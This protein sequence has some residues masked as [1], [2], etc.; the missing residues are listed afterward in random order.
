[1]PPPVQE[2]L[3]GLATEAVTIAAQPA[4]LAEAAPTL[5]ASLSL[6]LKFSVGRKQHERRTGCSLLRAVAGSLAAR[7]EGAARQAQHGAAGAAD[8]LVP[9]H[10]VLLHMA[11]IGTLVKDASEADAAGCPADSALLQAT[12]AS[13]PHVLVVLHRFSDL[14]DSVR[15]ATGAGSEASSGG[16]APTSDSSD[17]RGP[18]AAA[19]PEGSV[20]KWKARQGAGLVVAVQWQHVGQALS[21]SRAEWVTACCCCS[22]GRVLHDPFAAKLVFDS[23][24][25]GLIDALVCLDAVKE[26]LP[27][28]ETAEV[29]AAAAAAADRA[30]RLLPR[31]WH[32]PVVVGGA[33]GGQERVVPAHAAPA[34]GS[35]GMAGSLA[36]NAP[37][38]LGLTLCAL[39]FTLCATAANSNV[40]SETA[41][42]AV[43]SEAAALASFHTAVAACKWEWWQAAQ[44]EAAGVFLAQLSGELPP[45]PMHPA[46]LA[47]QRVWHAERRRLQH[48]GGSAERAAEMQRLVGRWDVLDGLYE[49]GW[50][51]CATSAVSCAASIAQ[52]H[53]VGNPSLAP[54]SSCCRRLDCVLLTYFEALTACP[55]GTS[56]KDGVQVRM[57]SCHCC[58]ACP[59][60]GGCSCYCLMG[61]S[62]HCLV[63]NTLPE[64]ASPP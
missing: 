56:P 46:C 37:Q 8:E 15:A 61:F 14:L 21:A 39:S 12:V 63:G 45:L 17:A 52:Q 36:R 54:C 5:A 62:W 4:H 23:C 18:G 20:G 44:E 41:A 29:L 31:L 55:A 51:L 43:S 3:V 24:Q 42:L 34:G 13:L 35:A 49:I 28:W 30:V 57:L 50:A 19:P 60:Y 38:A 25:I 26:G 59:G 32:W 2:A 22:A 48:S 16:A 40:S 53:A 6:A 64:F 10:L 9:S 47:A 1:M 11:L 7:L 27:G 33:G 58:S